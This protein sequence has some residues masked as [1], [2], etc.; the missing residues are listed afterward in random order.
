MHILIKSVSKNVHQSTKK[1][2]KGCQTKTEQKKG[3]GGR[4]RGEEGERKQPNTLS[5]T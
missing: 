5:S 1:I 3:E 4:G 2:Y